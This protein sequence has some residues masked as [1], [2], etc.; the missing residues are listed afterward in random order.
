MD[1]LWKMLS[2]GVLLKEVLLSLNMYRYRAGFSGNLSS[3][4]DEMQIVT[5]SI[6][7]K[8]CPACIGTINLVNSVIT[9]QRY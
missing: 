8:G 4:T 7:V 6:H 2:V 1:N 9:R 5:N 3:L